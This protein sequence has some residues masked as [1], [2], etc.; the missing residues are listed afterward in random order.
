[1]TVN[2]TQRFDKYHLLSNTTDEQLAMEMLNTQVVSL[3]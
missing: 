2:A 1:M 3:T